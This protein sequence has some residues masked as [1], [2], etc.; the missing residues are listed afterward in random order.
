MV[1]MEISFGVIQ[2]LIKQG[3]LKLRIDDLGAEEED[4]EADLGH[5]DHHHLLLLTNLL[6]L[7]KSLKRKKGKEK[8]T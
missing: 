4:H 5:V 2:I 8:T 7:S 1:Q 3:Y 6:N